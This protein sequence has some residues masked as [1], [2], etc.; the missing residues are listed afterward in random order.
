M[1]RRR[2]ISAATSPEAFTPITV[3]SLV[4]LVRMVEMG[5]LGCTGRIADGVDLNVDNLSVCQMNKI[6]LD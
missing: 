6:H 5:K 3:L 1:G 2:H 4:P